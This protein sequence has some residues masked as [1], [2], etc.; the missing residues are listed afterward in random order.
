MY[1]LLGVQMWGNF[2]WWPLFPIIFFSPGPIRSKRHK[3]YY[4]SIFLGCYESAKYW[5]ANYR[6]HQRNQPFKKDSSPEPK[7]TMCLESPASNYIALAPH[8]SFDIHTRM[9]FFLFQY[10]VVWREAHDNYST[11]EYTGIYRGLSLQ[12]YFIYVTSHLT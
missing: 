5:I 2:L 3:I 12:F 8:T 7:W 1:F 6:W 11:C 9:L 10:H 4:V